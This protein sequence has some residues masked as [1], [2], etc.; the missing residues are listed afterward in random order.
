LLS[1]ASLERRKLTSDFYKDF[2][3]KVCAFSPDSKTLAFV[4]ETSAF[5]GDIYLVPITGGEPK[6]LTFDGR[7]VLGLAWTPD[8][9]EIVYGSGRLWRIAASGGDPRSL[10]AFGMNPTISR[11]QGRMAYSN[12]IVNSDIWRIDLSAFESVDGKW[13]YYAKE[14][15]TGGIWKTP[16]AGGQES[17]VIDVTVYWGGWALVAEGIY[18]YDRTISKPDLC[19]I[20]SFR[21][22]TKEVT[23]I[24]VLP[25][26]PQYIAASPD[27]RWLIFNQ[28]DI[29]E[30]GIVLVENFR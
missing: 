16:V 18:Y 10:D 14:A 15:T 6:R 13:V 12:P 26:S 29:Y 7:D 27:Q 30:A 1:T 5:I 11:Q 22:A 3:D 2:G 24:A 25:K 23:T 8:G 20:N 17:L 21:F 4:R 19:Y 9:N 28:F